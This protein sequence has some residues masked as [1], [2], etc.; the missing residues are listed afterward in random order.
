MEYHDE[1]EQPT[2]G[3]H[4]RYQNVT[5]SAQTRKD[6]Q[7]IEEKL[8]EV[9]EV[10]RTF[11]EVSRTGHSKSVTKSRR[12]N[13]DS[14][15]TEVTGKSG[16]RE[17][18][19][20][21][22]EVI[23]DLNNQIENSISRLQV[24]IDKIDKEGQALKVQREDYLRSQRSEGGC[25][26]DCGYEPLSPESMVRSKLVAGHNPQAMASISRDEN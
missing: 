24:N 25:G 8:T 2:F 11:N 9:N 10:S 22:N 3:I 21:Y 26:G 19:Y 13:K 5:E 4:E 7:Y 1:T 17:P 15:A 6:L 16:L 20:K 18:K 12:S 23:T 14:K